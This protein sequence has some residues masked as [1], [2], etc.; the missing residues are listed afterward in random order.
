MASL[1]AYCQAY[2][3]WVAAEKAI[4]EHGLTFVTEKG[5]VRQR[6]E[7]AIAKESMRLI[8]EFAT[9]FGL[10]PSS[11]SRLHIKPPE[12]S[13]ELDELASRRRKMMEKQG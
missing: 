6:P 5:M 13:D 12:E 1:A 8:R 10:S 9:E 3:R 4:A 2:S 11:R 7:V